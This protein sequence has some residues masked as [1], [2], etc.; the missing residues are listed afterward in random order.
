[1]KNLFLVVSLMIASSS[2]FADGFVCRGNDL[3]VRTYNNVQPS[4]GTRNAA[5][6]VISDKT[7]KYGRKTIAKFKGENTLKNSGTNYVANVDLRYNNSKR[8]G[9]YIGGTRLGE[10]KTIELYVNY[11]YANP[12]SN[13]S[14]VEGQLLLNKRNRDVIPVALDCYRYLKN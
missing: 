4:E 1:M 11:S 12:R 7:V 14:H 5:I 8:K 6:L 13:G 10:L 9:E 3:V 2:A